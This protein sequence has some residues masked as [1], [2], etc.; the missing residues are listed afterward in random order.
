MYKYHILTKGGREILRTND[1]M[2]LEKAWNKA[3]KTGEGVFYRPPR[4]V[5]HVVTKVKEAV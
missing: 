3:R 1:L 2:V 4:P 5:A